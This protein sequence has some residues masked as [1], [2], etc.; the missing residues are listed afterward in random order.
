MDEIEK[1]GMGEYEKP[2]YDR[3]AAGQEDKG[4]GANHD[5]I[6]AIQLRETAEQDN[7]QNDSDDDALDHLQCAD[8][9]QTLDEE[10]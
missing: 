8:A 6:G 10:E 5:G 2:E 7:E 3:S 1:V 9:Y 4:A